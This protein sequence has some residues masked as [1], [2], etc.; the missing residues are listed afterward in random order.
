MHTSRC[1]WYLQTKINDWIWPIIIC[2]ML[3]SCCKL[4]EKVHWTRMNTAD[5]YTGH[6][7]C[8]EKSLRCDIQDMERCN[9]CPIPEH[10]KPEE[11]CNRRA[12]TAHSSRDCAQRNSCCK[13]LCTVPFRTW[14]SSC[15]RAKNQCN[16]LHHSAEGD[17]IIFVF[18]LFCEKNLKDLIGHC[19]YVCWKTIAIPWS[20]IICP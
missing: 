1:Y 2:K 15:R 9:R 17:S 3:I 8:S 5:C 7:S 12:T 4:I 14:T 11:T 20:E 19:S 16:P 13:T 10:R 18:F 6:H